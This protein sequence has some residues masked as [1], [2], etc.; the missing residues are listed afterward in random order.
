MAQ[1]L[2]ERFRPAGHLSWL[3]AQENWALGGNVG[4]SMQVVTEDT[5][6]QILNVA[7]LAKQ[8]R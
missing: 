6:C 3:W 5:N 4:N 7:S 2:L 8:R 1:N